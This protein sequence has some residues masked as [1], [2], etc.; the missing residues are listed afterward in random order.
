MKRL[1]STSALL[2][3]LAASLTSC[4]FDFDRGPY[5]ETS[6]TYN[7]TNF[8]RLD[9]GSSMNIRV[10]PSSTFS[11]IARGDRRDIEDLQVYV[12]GS[13]LI[14]RYRDNWF[15]NRRDMFITISMPTIRSVD[16][17]GSSNSEI[18]GF[19]NLSEFSVKLSG[20]SRSELDI[21][22]SRMTID[23]SGASNLRARGRGG[24]LNAELSG[25]S[26]IET[27]SFTVDEADLDLSGASNARVSVDRLLRVK[28]S[29]ASD[30]R[31]R[32]NPE[33]QQNLSGSSTVR[34]E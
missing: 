16:F 22:A 17:S 30:V 3:F 33:V 9:M 34:R 26:K 13:T 1:L 28:A 31:Y 2:L 20:A 18:S 12:Q 11:I 8:D 21:D 25:A 27:V 5:E 6:R 4:F 19:R 24:L 7:L 29:G 14:A 32:G 23:V 10:E 15:K